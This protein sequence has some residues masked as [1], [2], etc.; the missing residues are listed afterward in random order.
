METTANCIEYTTA[1][2]SVSGKSIEANFTGPI[3][4][5]EEAGYNLNYSHHDHARLYPA[6]RV[7]T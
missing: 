7:I 6:P 5:A 2:I 4:A 1:E 3:T